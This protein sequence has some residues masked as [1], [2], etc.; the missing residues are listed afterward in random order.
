MEA[1]LDGE[2][3][4]SSDMRENPKVDV[5]ESSVTRAL[6]ILSVIAEEGEAR[7]GHIAARVG[8]PTST[9][10]RLLSTLEGS[11]HV[12]RPAGSGHRAYLAGPALFDLAS[13]RDRAEAELV[14]RADPYHAS[15][16]EELGETAHVA[17]LR[18]RQTWFLA[19]H[20]SPRALRTGLRVGLGHPVEVSAAGRAILARLPHEDVCRL[21][22][23]ATANAELEHVLEQTRRQGYGLNIGNDEAHITAVGAAVIDPHSR[24]RGAL[25]VGGPTSR[26]PE[27]ILPWIGAILIKAADALGAELGS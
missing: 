25:T 17:V 24:V 27:S 8:I 22:D 7:L 14:R 11:G 26:L 2:G 20:E 19:G 6:R 15:L 12:M 18:G 4:Y 5:S 21:L 3:R 10:H 23:S 1:H 9:A 13:A 16:A